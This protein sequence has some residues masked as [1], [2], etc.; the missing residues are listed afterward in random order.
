MNHPQNRYFSA[1]RGEA[2]RQWSDIFRV[3]K[4][5]NRQTRIPYAV[6]ICFKSDSAI[7]IF[8]NKNSLPAGTHTKRN[9][10]ALQAEEKWSQVEGVQEIT[11]KKGHRWISLC[12][13]H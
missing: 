6:K 3:L 13:Q 4:E 12:K 7:R 2:R 10:G 5:N 11:N 9:R 1:A 8:L